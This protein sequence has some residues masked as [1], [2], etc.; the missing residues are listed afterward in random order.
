MRKS[1]HS[2]FLQVKLLSSYFLISMYCCWIPPTSAF[3]Q[4]SKEDVKTNLPLV[5]DEVYQ[6][7]VQ[8]YDYDQDI[9]LEARLVEKIEIDGGIR[10]KIVFTGI[11][12]TK[13]PAYLVLP[14]SGVGT[15]PVI[16]IV[17]GITGSK[18]RWFDDSSWPKGGLVIKSLLNKGFAVMILD[19]VYHGER[20]AE[21][22]Y[23]PVT[24]EYPI[25]AR[26]MMMQTAIEYRR[27]IDYLSTRTEIDTTRI[28]MLGLSMGGLITFQLTSLD[29]RIK[30]AVAGLTPL[31]KDAIYQPVLASTFASHIQCSSFLMLM[32]NKDNWYTITEARQLY[33]LI[34]IAQKE[35]VEYDTGHKPPIQYVDDVTDWFVNYLKP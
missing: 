6:S 25:A 22:E 1:I 8:F 32:G 20:S 9:P 23:A 16:L 11:N 33:D 24:L 30:T 7:I 10:E 14:K 12:H 28:G 21:N 17:D 13:V 34:P 5:S 18:E 15:Y 19:A 27:A 26:N 31:I 4:G 35:F 3:A 2:K 29:S